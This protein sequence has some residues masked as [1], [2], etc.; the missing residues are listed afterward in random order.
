MNHLKK[1]GSIPLLSGFPARAL[2]AS[3]LSARSMACDCTV[4][5]TGF[6]AQFLAF[7]K[8]PE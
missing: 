4:C 6:A 1:I 2:S 5:L 3:R 8:L 7:L